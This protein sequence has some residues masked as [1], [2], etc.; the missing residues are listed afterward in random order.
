MSLP[1]GSASHRPHAHPLCCIPVHGLSAQAPGVQLGEQ[2][3]ALTLHPYHPL[4]SFQPLPAPETP[5]LTGCPPAGHDEASS[6]EVTWPDGRVV[7]RAVASSETNSILEVPYPLDVEEPL[8][9]APLEVR[10]GC[11]HRAG[12]RNEELSSAGSVAAQG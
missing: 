3:E 7:A 4:A 9:P 1:T 11:G 5:P 10:A 6:L 12:G 8:M 2:G